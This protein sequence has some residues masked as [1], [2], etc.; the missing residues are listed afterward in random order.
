MNYTGFRDYQPGPLHELQYYTERLRRPA[1]LELA[2]LSHCLV[3][4]TVHSRDHD[5]IRARG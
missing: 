1:P 2:Q 3:L 5:P 4:A